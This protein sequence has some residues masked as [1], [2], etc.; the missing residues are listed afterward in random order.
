MANAIQLSLLQLPC[1]LSDPLSPP[2]YLTNTTTLLVTSKPIVVGRDSTCQVVYNM[3]CKTYTA[4]IIIVR[5]LFHLF[6]QI[7]LSSFVFGP[8]PQAKQGL[9]YP[10]V[11]AVKV[12]HNNAQRQTERLM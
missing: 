8:K 10:K 12:V 7:V 4:V 2:D 5:V 6:P 9:C 3:G 1:T 11:N